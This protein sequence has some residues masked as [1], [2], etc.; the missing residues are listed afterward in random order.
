MNRTISKY[1]STE[2][3][4]KINFQKHELLKIGKSLGLNHPLTISQSQKLDQLI[5][6]YQRMMT[7]SENHLPK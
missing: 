2:L 5:Y 6:Q 7:S 4:D 1:S 3:I